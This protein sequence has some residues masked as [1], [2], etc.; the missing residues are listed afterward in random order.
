MVSFE[1]RCGVAGVLPTYTSK[2]ARNASYIT[3][4]Y[5]KSKAMSHAGVSLLGS[6]NKQTRDL[7]LCLPAQTCFEMSPPHGQPYFTVFIF[8][9]ILNI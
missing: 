7:F 4:P 1:Y 5:T 6:Q 9:V 3:D 8:L 2:V